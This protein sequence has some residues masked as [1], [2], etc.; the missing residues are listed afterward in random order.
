MQQSESIV[1]YLLKEQYHPVLLLKKTSSDSPSKPIL[2][3]HINKLT[4]NLKEKIYDGLTEEE[5]EGKRLK[6]NAQLA[7]QHSIDKASQNDTLEEFESIDPGFLFHVDEIMS[8]LCVLEDEQHIEF[9]LL[10]PT[11]PGVGEK[12]HANPISNL[13][14]ILELSQTTTISTKSWIPTVSPPDQSVLI[15]KNNLTSLKRTPFLKFLT[16][17]LWHQNISF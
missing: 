8:K 3:T 17:S 10:P 11:T 12:S 15:P 2:K 9:S 1:D 5:A 16:H 14:K 6:V 13:D 7:V 4:H